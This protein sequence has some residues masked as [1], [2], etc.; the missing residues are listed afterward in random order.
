[1]A[2]DDLETDMFDYFVSVQP[3]GSKPEIFVV[4]TPG[5]SVRPIA[6]PRP[7]QAKWYKQ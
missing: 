1:M 5:V 7:E 3:D 6:Q 4:N 2:G